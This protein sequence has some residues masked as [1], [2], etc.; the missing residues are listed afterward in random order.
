MPAC[1]ARSSAGPASF[2]QRPPPAAGFT[3]AKK[4]SFTF[5]PACHPMDAV[6]QS[7]WHHGFAV[8]A[9]A[10]LRPQFHALD[11]HGGGKREVPLPNKAAADAFVIN[12]AAIP[13][14]DR[15]NQ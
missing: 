1:R 14:V 15:G 6:R 13:V 9:F 5:E 7:Q 8:E 10:N 2:P 3:I 4:R 12:Q 11:F